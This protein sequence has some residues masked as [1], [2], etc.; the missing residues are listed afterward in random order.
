MGKILFF[1]VKANVSDIPYVLRNQVNKNLSK[2]DV[3][4]MDILDMGGYLYIFVLVA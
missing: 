3:L 1:Y 2:K 4:S